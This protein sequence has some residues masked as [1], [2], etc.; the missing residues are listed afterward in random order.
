MPKVAVGILIKKEKNT[1]SN[2]SDEMS[3]LL[4]QRSKNA[5]YP[6]KWEFPGGKIEGDE[7]APEALVREVLEELNVRIESFSLYFQRVNHYPD[8]RNFD[9]SYFLVD[10]FSGEMQ[11]L[12]FENIAWV[13]ISQLTTFDILEGNKEIIEMLLET[14][15]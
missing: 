3:V 13:R 8:G 10:D 11:N 15:A 14:Y 9:V 6:L 1:I 5:L 12:E 7:S 4:C 2:K